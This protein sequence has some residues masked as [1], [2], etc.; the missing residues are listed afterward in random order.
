MLASALSSE[1]KRWVGEGPLERIS[2]PRIITGAAETFL[3]LLAL[4]GLY[5][6]VLIP[7]IFYV[8]TDPFRR[9][10]GKIIQTFTRA[11]Q[12]ERYQSLNVYALFLVLFLACLIFL[13]GGL[14]VG[15]AVPSFRGS[16]G[17][18]S[19]AL[20]A[21][22]AVVCLLAFTLP[23]ILNPWASSGMRYEKVDLLSNYG[24]V[25]CLTFPFAVYSGYLGGKLAKRLWR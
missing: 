21:T 11:Q 13:L 10:G 24:L 22:L 8:T 3:A 2:W 14:V 18:A 12:W 5:R 6:W 4:A 17:A 16:N 1:R 7:Y 25:F 15:R 19:A 9:P 20:A 23:W